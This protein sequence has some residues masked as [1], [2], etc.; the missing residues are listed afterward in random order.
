MQLKIGAIIEA[1]MTSSRL[2]GKHLL[3]VLGEPIIGHLIRRLQSIPLIDEV[4]VAMTVRHEDDELES[5]V[6]SIGASV[7]RGDEDDVMGRVLCAARKSNIDIICEVTGDCPVI[8][9]D[10]AEQIIKTFYC[11]DVDYANN[12]KFGGLP[13]GMS[14]QVFS[15]DTLAKSESMT[16]DPLDREHVTLHIKRNPEIFPPM[17]LVAEKSLRWPE[18]ALTL[19]ERSDYLL[20]KRIIEHFGDNNP[21]FSCGDIV[22]LL[23]QNPE[24]LHINQHVKRKGDT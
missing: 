14:C 8:D 1:R 24:W 22:N 19:D 2:P 12:G 6:S 20:L 11:N 7:F 3:P 10:L 23:R 5:Y 17:Y 9:I 13:D 18:L 15:T 16:S 21:F 4:I